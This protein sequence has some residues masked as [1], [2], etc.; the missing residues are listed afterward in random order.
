MSNSVATSDAEM[1]MSIDASTNAT[2]FGSSSP[3]GDVIVPR[4]RTLRLRTRTNTMGFGNPNESTATTRNLNTICRGQHRCSLVASHAI[5]RFVS[6]SRNDAVK[7]TAEVPEFARMYI[8]TADKEIMKHL[9]AERRLIA[10]S[11]HPY[12]FCFR[13]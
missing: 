7:F 3:T 10:Q 13:K 5:E 12:P 6:S 1:T 2:S 4:R 8:E 11:L 9:K